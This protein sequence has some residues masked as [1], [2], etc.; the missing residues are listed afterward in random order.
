M[1]TGI[2]KYCE[3]CDSLKSQPWTNLSEIQ[4]Q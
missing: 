4:K 2:T 3:H 1:Y